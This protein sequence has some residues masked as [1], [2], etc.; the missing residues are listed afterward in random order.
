VARL[1]AI[2]R[3]RRVDIGPPAVF[4]GPVTPL[5]SPLTPRRAYASVAV[6]LDVVRAVRRAL[7]VT[8]NDVLLALVAGAV[9]S[10]LVRRGEPADRPLV[11]SVP[12]SSDEPGTNRLWGNRTSTLLTGL[13][14]DVADPVDRVRSAAAMATAAKGVQDAAGRHTMEDW[15]EYSPA[16]TYRLLWRRLVPRV[17]RAPI[18]LIVSNVIGPRERL[19]IA[20]AELVAIQSVGPLLEG[21]GLNVTAWSYGDRLQVSVLTCADTVPDP[22]ELTTGLVEALVELEQR[23]G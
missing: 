14:V 20:G 23:I 18:N 6:D 4:T 8:V 5:A 12:V 10:W 19:S 21:V 3:A 1:P 11:V 22:H 9:R 15:V 7:E 16:F 17:G 2:R 13:P